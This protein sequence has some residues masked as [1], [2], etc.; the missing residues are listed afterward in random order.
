[1][2]VDGLNTNK[3]IVWNF[4]NYGEFVSLSINFFS[5]SILN[6]L[7]KYVNNVNVLV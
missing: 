2:A 6:G 1:M 4:F 5:I 3:I 7:V